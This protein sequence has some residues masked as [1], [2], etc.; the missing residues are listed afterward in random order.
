MVGLS[1]VSRL[2]IAP[3]AHK[4]RFRHRRRRLIAAV[5]PLLLNAWIIPGQT[6]AAAHIST[7]K[8]QSIAAAVVF[9]IGGCVAAPPIWAVAT[10]AY[11]RR[12]VGICVV[13]RVRAGTVVVVVGEVG[14]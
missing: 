7:V 1:F 14:G 12:I 3:A 8:H 5:M 4:K 6:T 11:L 9:V 2:A 10:A 13:R